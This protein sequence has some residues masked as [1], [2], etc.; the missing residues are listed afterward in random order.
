[1]NFHVFLSDLCLKVAALS[2]LLVAFDGMVLTLDG[3]PSVMADV[4]RDE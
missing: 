1:M 3:A 2:R 4:S